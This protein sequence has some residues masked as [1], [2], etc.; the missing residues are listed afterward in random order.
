M[1]LQK[2]VAAENA[3]TRS[4]TI[5][6]RQIELGGINYI[7][8]LNAQHTYFQ[9]LLAHIQARSPLA[10]PTARHYSRPWAAAGGTARTRRSNIRFLT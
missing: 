9:A 2:A 8:V 4:F 6:P 7:L 3:V 10:F 5:A 1:A